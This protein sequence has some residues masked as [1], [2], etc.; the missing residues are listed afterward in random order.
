MG[1]L[2]LFPPSL[3]A[4][5]RL[6]TSHSKTQ[7]SNPIFCPHVSSTTSKSLRFPSKTIAF[8]SN[9]N[10]P[11]ESI[12]LDENGAVDDMDGYMNYLSLEY[13]SVWDTKPSWCQ[14]WTIVLTGVS[15]IASSW[16]IVHSIVVTVVILLLI[17]TWW[18]IFLYSYPK[19]YS[20]MISERRRRVTNGVEDT[21]G[22]GRGNES[23]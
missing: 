15:V 16:L 12:F 21:F 8:G 3:T 7:L 14:P 22:F 13:D 11:K 6:C 17:C 2:S 4:S 23:N 19:A 20:E 10:D 18:Y 9:A 5:F 1:T